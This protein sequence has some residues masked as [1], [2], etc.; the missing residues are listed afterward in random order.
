[1][2]RDIL[3]SAALAALGLTPVIHS[4]AAAA[5]MESKATLCV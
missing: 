1:M 3:V 5:E 2:S 4:P